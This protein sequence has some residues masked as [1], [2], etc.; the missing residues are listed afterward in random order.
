M[1][2]NVDDLIDSAAKLFRL[3]FQEEALEA[4]RRR[5]ADI[6]LD[7]IF[8]LQKRRDFLIR[9]S[10]GGTSAHYRREAMK[11]CQISPVR[12]LSPVPEKKGARP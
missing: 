7:K 9:A 11:L 3:A 8:H 12:A 6:L 5:E 10:T 4:Q 1:N 2:R